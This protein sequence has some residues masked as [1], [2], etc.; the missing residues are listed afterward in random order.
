MDKNLQRCIENLAEGQKLS[1]KPT[2]LEHTVGHIM[3]RV[4][5]ALGYEA[6]VTPKAIKLIIGHF[7]PGA[8]FVCN[9]QNISNLAC[10]IAG[11]V[12]LNKFLNSRRY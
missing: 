4:Y 7:Q 1:C 2:D 9:Q 12:A 6:P 10:F 3:A 5:L 11:Y 8:D